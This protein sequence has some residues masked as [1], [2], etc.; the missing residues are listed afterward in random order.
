MSLR[1]GL[2]L[3]LTTL[4]L[5]G[6]ESMGA[7]TLNIEPG[8]EVE[9]RDRLTNEYLT[10]TPRGVVREGTFQDSLRE[11]GQT[12]EIPPRTVSLIGADERPGRYVVQLD[13]EGYRPWDTVGVQAREGDCHV[14]TASF[15]AAMDPAP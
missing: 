7:C 1:I 5:A 6:C 10:V 4:T 9:V 15:T 2:L 13:A 11:G 12:L 8:V 3:C 14:Q